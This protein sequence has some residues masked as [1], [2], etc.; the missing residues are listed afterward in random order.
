MSNYSIGISGITAAQKALE[1]I[2]NNI[3]NAA[4][5]GYHCQ[6][7][8]LSPAYASQG[9][10]SMLGG[11]VK[12]AGVA[13]KIDTLLEQ[14]ILR[15][16]SALEQVN[17]ELATLQKVENAFGELSTDSGLNAAIDEFFN[18]LGELAANC[19]DP[20]WQ[21]NA[22]SA[23][24]SMAGQFTSLG[25][26]LERTQA[27]VV[28]EAQAAVG[29]IN[30]LI[31]SIAELNDKI[32]RMEIA[33]GQANNLRDQ[34]DQCI[35]ELSEMTGLEVQQRE[36]GVI[37]VRVG[38]IPVVAGTVATNLQVGL[39]Q[40]GQLALSIEGAQNYSTQAQGGTLGGLAELKNNML[41]EIQNE[42]D[43]LANAVMQ[44]VNQLHVQAVGLDGSFT[45]LTGRTMTSENIA[46][47]EPAVTDGVVQVRVVNTNTGEVA[48]YEINV[49]AQNDSLSDI[50][51]QID[52]LDGV[53]ASVASSQ[54]HIQADAGYEFDFLPSVLST[55]TDSNLTA[56]SPPEMSV[57]GIYTGSENQTFQCTVVGNESVGN[58]TLQL[59]VRNGSGQLVTTVNVGS[60]Y[61]AGDKISIG[62]GIEITLSMGELN[63]N[64]TF[65]IDAFANTDTAGLLSAVGINTFFS[66]TSASN[67]AVC[68]DIIDSPSRIATALGAEMTDNTN[69]VRLAGL[70]NEK[71][72]DLDNLT[73]GGFYR[74][75]I[76]DVGQDISV[77]QIREENTSAIV[78]NLIA[79]Q[80][81][82]SGVDINDEAAQMLIFEQMFQAMSKYLNTIQKSIESIMD[83]I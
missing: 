73:I 15:Q 27:Q 20:I 7:I 55:P 58:G 50:A 57:S 52:A 33:G 14:E 40:A 13:R 62:N 9:A 17:V 35:S 31:D 79:Q 25:Q 56:A 23:A 49:D 32:E 39:D 24:E 59:E 78:Q 60:G 28:L 53:N 4:T 1:V 16:K 61:A 67:M 8:E 80:S 41:V 44:Q 70:Q 38:E 64:D 2:G 43:A 65:E 76:T 74:K 3:A 19:E 11:G 71:L 63:E 36:F 29:N 81:E 68:S 12:V 18:A 72:S 51:A 77:K 37:D 34:R 69:A 46:D 82:L 5:E 54:L 83:I 42:F 75:L 48:R 26:F 6:E 22:V 21:N 45:E 10:A 30:V 47:F 66:G